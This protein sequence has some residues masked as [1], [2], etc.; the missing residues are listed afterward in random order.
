[1][2]FIE[3]NNST[4]YTLTET[5]RGQYMIAGLT[6]DPNSKYRLKI[7]ANQKEY[8]SDFVPVNSNP[9]IDSISWSYQSDGVHISANTHDPSNTAKYFQ[10]DFTETWEI[11]SQY[12]PNT[13]YNS[14]DPYDV[15]YF[16]PFILQI[17]DS[18]KF[19]C[20]QADTSQII[21]LGSTDKYSIDT[22]SAPTTIVEK[23][24]VK[25]SVLY[26]IN[27]RQFALTKDGFEFLQKMQKNS[28]Q[29]G[30]VFDAQPS[31]LKGNIHSVSDPSEMVIGNVSICPIQEKR[32]FISNSDLPDWNYQ[33][34]CPIEIEQNDAAFI[35][36]HNYAADGITALLLP[37][38]WLT[39][40]SFPPPNGYVTTFT[41]AEVRCVDCTAV[42]TKSKPVFWPN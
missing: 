29:L 32:I 26:S 3:G 2:V 31:E 1:Q 28:T 42:G 19:Q 24:S 4:N 38:E 10:W 30:T 14:I 6:L 23:G 17:H 40:T 36:D 25:M 21:L 22:I 15:V 13:M 12:V 34:N 16:N 8:D 11:H 39:R 5:T 9:P 37:I 41:S 35:R 27:V 33:S 18:S 7:V 20:W